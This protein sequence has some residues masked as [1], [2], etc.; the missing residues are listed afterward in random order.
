VLLFV[1]RTILSGSVARK[2]D[3]ENAS[4][5]S[6]ACSVAAGIKPEEEDAVAAA[7]KSRYCNSSL[8]CC[9]SNKKLP[10]IVVAAVAVAETG[11]QPT[12]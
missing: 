8:R 7:A 12:N 4:V 11:R 6:A 5:G 1:F 9:W 10:M 2:R 3:W